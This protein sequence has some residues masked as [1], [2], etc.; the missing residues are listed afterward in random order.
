MTLFTVG[1]EG[2]DIED[3]T[4]F[5]RKKKIRQVADLRK[6]PVSRKKGFSKNRLAAALAEKKIEY[7]HIGALGVPRD[8]RKKNKEGLISRK[9]MFSDYVKKILPKAQDELK[10]L[11]ADAGSN[12]LAIL[13]YEADASDCHRHFVAL[14]LKKMS[15]RALEIKDLYPLT[16]LAHPSGLMPKMARGPQRPARGS[17]PKSKRKESS[18]PTA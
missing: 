15:R 8:W 2:C 14:A 11:L 9:K 12:S 6:N 3:F 7:R 13:C 17:P 5:L 10:V 1:Y 16:T 18:Q 4:E